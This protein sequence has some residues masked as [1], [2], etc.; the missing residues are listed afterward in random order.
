M[1]TL[2]GWKLL[3]DAIL[4]V[5]WCL[6]VCLVY[7]PM[8][9][10]PLLP[11]VTTKNVS[12]HWQISPGDVWQI[13]SSLRPLRACCH[14][15]CV[16]LFANL[17]TVATR[18]LSPWGFSRQEYWNGLPGLPLRNHPDRGIEPTSLTCIDRRVLYHLCHLGNPWDHYV[19]PLKKKRQKLA[20]LV[21]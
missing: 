7:P 11:V 19:R 2:S 20:T 17:W 8:P 4:Y 3:W 21:K 14:F 5:V 13:H 9:V 10:E 15:S 16:P 18:L 12:R 1:L 6:A